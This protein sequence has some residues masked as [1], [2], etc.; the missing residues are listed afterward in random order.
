MTFQREQRKLHSGTRP[1]L[2][3]Q[4][5]P[6]GLLAT[7]FSVLRQSSH[8]AYDAG[9]FDALPGLLAQGGG[10]PCWQ[11]NA[12][13][14]RVG[15]D[16]SLAQECESQALVRPHSLGGRRVEDDGPVRVLGEV[17]LVQLV[18]EQL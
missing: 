8:G 15:G 6:N 9:F 11:T 7:F 14:V 16:G 5:G 2:V 17:Y 4:D 13:L 1:C 10:A 18:L 12:S 3:V